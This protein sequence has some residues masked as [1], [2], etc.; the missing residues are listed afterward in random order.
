M[1]NDV[2]N[3]IYKEKMIYDETISLENWKVI[4]IF[5]FPRIFLLNTSFIS[6]EF[7]FKISTKSEDCNFVKKL[8]EDEEFVD[9]Q[10]NSRKYARRRHSCLGVGHGVDGPSKA[11]GCCCSSSAVVVRGVT[12]LNRMFLSSPFLFWSDVTLLDSDFSE[13]SH[14]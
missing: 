7:I 13:S 11:V 10:W 4:S 12:L 6:K 5:G 9:Y 8:E 2:Q 14:R 1:K 3:H